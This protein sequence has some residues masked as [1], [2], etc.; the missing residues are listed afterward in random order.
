MSTKPQQVKKANQTSKT[1]K[2]GILRRKY[3][4][5]TNLRFYKPKTLKLASKPKY[6]RSKETLNLPAKFDKF[7]VLVHPLNT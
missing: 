4:I 2:K 1:A 3:Q 7:S 5:R 6:L